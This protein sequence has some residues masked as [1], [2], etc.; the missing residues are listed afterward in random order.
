VFECVRL[1]V[2]ASV[3]LC[4]F[5]IC[6]KRQ[7]KSRHRRRGKE[8]MHAS[9]AEAGGGSGR[10]GA[11]TLEGAYIS[12]DS[13]ERI[14]LVWLAGRLPLHILD[15]LCESSVLALISRLA[16]ALQSDLAETGPAHPT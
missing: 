13:S 11:E 14:D 7:I 6:E 10:V 9:M 3:R 1:C 8:P 5:V 16:A 2:C 4:V 15:V 12:L